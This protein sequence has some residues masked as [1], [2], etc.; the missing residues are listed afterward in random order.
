MWSKKTEKYFIDKAR[1][2]LS[3]AHNHARSSGPV[4]VARNG[5]LYEIFP[6]GRQNFIKNLDKPTLVEMGLKVRIR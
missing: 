3:A 4:V 5:S 2:T 1:S 6:D